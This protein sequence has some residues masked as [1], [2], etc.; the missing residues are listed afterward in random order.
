MF[1]ICFCGWSGELVA[2]DIVTHDGAQ[3][4]ACPRCGRVDDLAWLGPAARDGLLHAAA[5][6]HT[7]PRR[8]HPRPERIPA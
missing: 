4:L 6:R 2:K 5:Q 7:E 1:E 3:A 8:L